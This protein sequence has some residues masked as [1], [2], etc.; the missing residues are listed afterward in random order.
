MQPAESISTNGVFRAAAIVCILALGAGIVSFQSGFD[1]ISIFGFQTSNAIPA[2]G[3]PLRPWN[4]VGGCGVSAGGGGA[5]GSSL[6]WIGPGLTGYLLETRVNLTQTYSTNALDVHEKDNQ[7]RSHLAQS[8]TLLSPTFTLKLRNLETSLSIPFAGKRSAT[9]A[10]AGLGDLGVTQAF[11]FG[12]TGQFTANVGITVPTGNHTIISEMSALSEYLP[13]EMQLG[14]GSMGLTAGFDAGFDSY[15]GVWGFGVSYSGGLLAFQVTEVDYDTTLQRKVITEKELTYAREG[16]G[17]RNQV[18][19]VAP[20]YVSTKFFAGFK[21]RGIMNGFS[22]S[23]SFPVQKGTRMQRLSNSQDLHKGEDSTRLSFVTREDAQAYTDTARN[24]DG[25]PMYKNPTVLGAYPFLKGEKWKVEE[26][27]EI[28]WRHV[29]ILQLQY[30]IAPMDAA[31]PWMI[32]VTV[33]FMFDK[34]ESDWLVPRFGGISLGVVLQ[35]GF[36]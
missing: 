20:D 23:P 28:L 29:P 36:F 11:R 10:V 19:A 33:P 17:V 25:T 31:I 26:R 7:A 4:N 13:P 1:V 27:E 16:W 18:G 8:S 35:Y 30:S 34:Y 6:T 21:M 15:W 5:G 3:I 32:G 2:A 12:S 22:L 24:E 14:T 9:D